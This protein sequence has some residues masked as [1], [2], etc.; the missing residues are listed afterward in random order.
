[1]EDWRLVMTCC[2]DEALLCVDGCGRLVWEQRG[3][4]FESIDI[5]CFQPESDEKHILVDIDHTE[6]NLSLLQIYGECGALVGEINTVYSRHHLMIKW[7]NEPAEQFVACEERMLVSGV[8]GEPLARFATPMPD[9]TRFDQSTRNS[10][11]AKRG[12]F[13]L[14]GHT[15]NLFGHGRDDLL[16]TTNPGG[17]VWTYRNSGKQGNA[18]L[19]TG[20]NV[21]LY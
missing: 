2:A 9:N 21:T 6:P 3:R 18:L 17:A 4:H 1:M 7:A 8:T 11:H 16:L 15:A 12:V 13:H 19:G 10:E 20:C 14:L 5:G